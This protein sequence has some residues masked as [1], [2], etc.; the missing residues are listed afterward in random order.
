M[1]NPWPRRLPFFSAL[2]FASLVAALALR[3]P[4]ASLAPRPSGDFIDLHDAVGDHATMLS[5]GHA[6]FSCAS[7]H[8]AHTTKAPRPLWQTQGSMDAAV[9]SRDSEQAGGVK[10]GLCM[11]CHDGTV[12]PTIKAHSLSPGSVRLS[13]QGADLSANHPVGV[14]YMAALRR[15]PGSYNDPAM[16]ARIV[17]EDGMVGCVSCHATHDISAV[18]AGNVRPEVCIECHRR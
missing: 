16:N 7:C 11:S 13:S 17:L 15:D 18:S 10:T 5:A 3:A 2:V 12:A 1:T 14:D 6:S 9:F 8:F 4:R